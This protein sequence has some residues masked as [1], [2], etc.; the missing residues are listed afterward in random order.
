MTAV[1]RSVALQMQG[2][3]HQCEA[4]GVIFMSKSPKRAE[5]Q[6]AARRRFDSGAFCDARLEA[7]PHARAPRFLAHRVAR[8][9]VEGLRTHGESSRGAARARGSVE[10]RAKIEKGAFSSSRGSGPISPLKK[11]QM[12]ER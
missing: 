5:A 12:P 6:R 7:A 9:K 10:C 3:R 8:Q 11:R 1:T 2:K 4:P